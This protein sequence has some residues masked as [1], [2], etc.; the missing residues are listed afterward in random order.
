MHTISYCSLS[1]L[2]FISYRRSTENFKPKLVYK[3]IVYQIRIKPEIQKQKKKG[4]GREWFKYLPRIPKNC[5]T[6]FFS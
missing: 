5:I 3:S 2:E 1:S 6:S 4:C